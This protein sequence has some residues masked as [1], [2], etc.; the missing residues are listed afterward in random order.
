M[1]VESPLVSIVLPTR[2]GHRYIAQSIESCLSQSFGDFE[3][4]VV[5]GASTDG[6]LGVVQSFK[7][8]R[9]RVL[10]QPENAGLLPGALNFGFAQARGLLYTWTQD[11]DYFAPEALQVMVDGLNTHPEAG[12]VYAQIYF[13]NEEGVVCREEPPRPPE[14]LLWTNPIGHCFMYRRSIAEQIGEYAVA[15]YLSEDTQY[16]MRIYKHTKIVQLPGRYFYHRLHSGSLTL[17]SYGAYKALRV[18]ARARREVLGL[19]WFTYRQQLAAAY[20][21]EAFAAHALADRQHVVACV[22]RG[23]L[24][25][26]TWLANRGVGSI[27]LKGLLNRA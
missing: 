6:T 25:D 1:S 10:N 4:I 23:V 9:I 13:I 5:D 3:L 14:A 8:A 22:V 11:D 19:P 24:N 20:I 16:W 15:F 7:D 26:P 27:A 21:E 12:M 18:A 2:N 17:R